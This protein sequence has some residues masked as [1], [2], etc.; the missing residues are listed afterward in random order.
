MIKKKKKDT[1]SDELRKMLI[2]ILVRDKLIQRKWVLNRKS[3]KYNY[4]EGKQIT[5]PDT[6]KRVYEINSYRLPIC[7][8][9]IRRHEKSRIFKRMEGQSR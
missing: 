3:N 9:D 4:F 8:Y 5:D 1:K 6:G 2:I 7:N